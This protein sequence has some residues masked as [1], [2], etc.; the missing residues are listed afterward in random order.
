MKMLN[1]HPGDKRAPL[2]LVHFAL[3]FSTALTVSVCLGC[4]LSFALFQIWL[5][6]AR[7]PLGSAMRVCVAVTAGQVE[8]ILYSPFISSFAPPLAAVCAFIPWSP[9]MPQWAHRWTLPP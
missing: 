6:Q 7:L 5:P 9:N 8:A 4:V 3:P 1:F 2:R